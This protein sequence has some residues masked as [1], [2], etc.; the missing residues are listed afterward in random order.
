[1]QPPR[2][3]QSGSGIVSTTGLSQKRTFNSPYHPPGS[4]QVPREIFT[5]L[6][7]FTSVGIVIARAALRKELSFIPGYAD[8]IL[9]GGGWN[10]CWSEADIGVGELHLLLDN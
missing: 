10:H 6:T 7:K 1:M 2:R 9:L 3:R 5:V 8:A 4:E